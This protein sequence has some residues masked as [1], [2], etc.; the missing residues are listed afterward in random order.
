MSVNPINNGGPAFPVTTDCRHS[1]MSLRDYFAA[2][3]MQGIVSHWPSSGNYAH[4][5]SVA[6]S[7]AQCAYLIADAMIARR[8]S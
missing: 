5:A 3:A 7:V 4:A 6:E 2:L 8:G 1:G